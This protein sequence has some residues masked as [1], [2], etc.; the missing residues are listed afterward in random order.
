[1][2]KKSFLLAVVSFAILISGTVAGQD[3]ERY[4]Q[5]YGFRLPVLSAGEY[6]VSGSGFY[7]TSKS[8]RT[9]YS[10]D[11]TLYD[12]KN[13]YSSLQ[14]TVAITDR[15]LVRGDLSYYPK[16]TVN[17]YTGFRC[18]R[19][20]VEQDGYLSPSLLVV[21]RPVRS[22]ELYGDFG[23]STSDLLTYEEC[24][25]EAFYYRETKYRRFSF[26]FTLQGRL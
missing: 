7:Y 12:Y 5:P 1:M 22:L 6:V 26:G 4:Y 3:T 16:Q 24:S 8:V 11:T 21:Y 20:Y 19:E 2:V 25:D 15:F 14:A 17:D 9:D 10:G 18:E 23:F 13:V